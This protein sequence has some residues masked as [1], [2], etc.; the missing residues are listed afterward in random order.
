MDPE[1]TEAETL[2][3]D[4]EFPWLGYPDEDEY[5]QDCN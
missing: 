2:D 4:P 3:S 1:Y 5:E